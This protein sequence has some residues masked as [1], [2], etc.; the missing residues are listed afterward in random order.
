MLSE[1]ML[2]GIVKTMTKQHLALAPTTETMMPPPEPGKAY[3]LYMHVPFCQRLCPY[4]SFNRYPFKEE[5]AAPYFANMRKEMLMLKDLGYDFES[6]YIGGGTP[7]IMID[8]LCETIDLARD[9]FNIKEVSSETNPNHLTLPYLEKL[10]GRV[11]RLSV[12][13]QS[14]NDGLLKQ[15]DRYEKYGSGAEIME[16]IAEATPYFDSLNVDMIFNFP[17]QTEEILIDDLEKVVESGCRQT[18]FSPLYVSSA[19]T[20]KMTTTLGT[21]D[22]NREYRFYQILDE[23]LTGG[24]DPFFDRTTLWTFNRIDKTV[25]Q[26]HSLLVEEYAVAYEEYPAI[27]SGAISS[28]NSCL[29]VNDFSI[30]D[31][32]AAIESGHMSIMGKT[33]LS[34]ADLMRYRFLLQLY[35]LR[36]DKKKFKQDFGCS[37]E[38]GLPVEMAFMR[39]NKAFATDNAEEL[40]LTPIGRYLTLVM[41]RQFLSGMNN[42]RD[43]ARA[44]LSGAE[45][46]LLFGEGTPA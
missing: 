16:R 21:M 32:N 8:E 36:L 45:R 34:R 20:R 41:Y 35:N 1:R 30:S 46:E 40:T 25:N 22:Y 6:I 38:A 19:T 4:C 27:G 26:D 39:A 13:V 12:G 29:Y 14:F 43:Q 18:T 3:M 37:V 5:I 15:M 31:Y 24:Q 10:K 28:L 11:Q 44:A 7:T 17:S 42:L 33:K 9:N 23:V 2:S